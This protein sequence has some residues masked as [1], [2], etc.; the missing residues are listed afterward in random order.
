MCSRHN[1]MRAIPWKHTA[2]E[3]FP[4]SDVDIVAIRAARHRH[5]V[6]QTDYAALMREAQSLLESLHALPLPGG[7]GEASASEGPAKEGRRT[8][9][10]GAAP[11]AKAAA[12]AAAAASASASAS[13]PA[14]GVG[15]DAPP[16]GLVRGALPDGPAHRAG[17][18]SGMEVLRF[19]SATAASVAA[20]GAGLDSLGD[21]LQASAGSAVDVV[22]RTATAAGSDV[23]LLRL[24]VPVPPRIGL[25]VVPPP[26]VEQAE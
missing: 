21:I 9:E 25:H 1:A 22:V 18:R 11:A 17:L 23:R 19:G 7:E 2:A 26:P 15:R 12:P 6:L 5:S 20:G 4:R 16:V 8:A 24:A 10:Y 14:L 13:A 3:G